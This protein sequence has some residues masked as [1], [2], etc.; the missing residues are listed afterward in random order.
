MTP[1]PAQIAAGLAASYALRDTGIPAEGIKPQ[2]FTA[3]PSLH[4]RVILEAGMA[5]RL[6][7]PEEVK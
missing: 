7:P 3:A 4:V 1:T 2:T 6:N 5:R